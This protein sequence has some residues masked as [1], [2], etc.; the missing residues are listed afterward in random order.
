MNPAELD[1]KDM[2]VADG[3]V[4]FKTDFF[5]GPL[6][7]EP[8]LGAA[9]QAYSNMP[10]NPLTDA[11]TLSELM[12]NINVRGPASEAGYKQSY[13]LAETI[14]AGMVAV[15][16]RSQAGMSYTIKK[17]MIIT[18]STLKAL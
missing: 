13:A 3:V 15:I 18:L 17:T 5:I 9:I 12:V 1:I 14:S 8:S 4:T 10:Y 16:H 7:E 2:L 11:A 6:P